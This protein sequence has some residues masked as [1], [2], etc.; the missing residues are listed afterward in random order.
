MESR[1]YTNPLAHFVFCISCGRKLGRRGASVNIR[2]R[3]DRFGRLLLV[4]Q[5]V[6]DNPL[7]LLT[8]GNATVIGHHVEF[9]HLARQP[10]FQ[11]LNQMGLECPLRPS[12]NEDGDPHGRPPILPIRHTSS[13]VYSESHFSRSS[14]S[15]RVRSAAPSSLTLIVTI[16]VG[17]RNRTRR[18][19]CV[20]TI[21]CVC[22]DA[23]RRRSASKESSSGCK[24]TSGSS[25]MVTSGKPGLCNNVTSHKNRKV[26]SES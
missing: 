22:W 18:S 24:L 13:K 5:Q 7:Q 15:A 12:L 21:S 26:P 6:L 20:A 11:E 17:L 2:Q 16:S 14:S 10:R 25:I 3:N 1:L 4:V 8:R 9:G 19:A 23:S